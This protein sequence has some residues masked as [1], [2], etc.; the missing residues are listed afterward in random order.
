M[1]DILQKLKMDVF[2]HKLNNQYIE[3]NLT[4]WKPLFEMLCY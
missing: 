2:L 4:G 1:Q 3:I